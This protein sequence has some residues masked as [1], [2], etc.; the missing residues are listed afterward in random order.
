M[1]HSLP[2]IFNLPPFL[3]RGVDVAKFNSFQKILF[4]LKGKFLG[5]FITRLNGK[6]FCS[7][8]NFFFNNEEKI[9][10]E[11][12]FYK[13]TLKTGDIY[14]PNKRILRMVNEPDIQLKKLLES[15]CIADVSLSEGDV[16]IDCGA[17][18]GELNV[19][20]QNNDIKINYIAFEPDPETFECLKLN[21]P[22][23]SNNLYNKALSNTNSKENFY[24][25]NLGGN[26]SLINF[27]NNDSIIVST[28]TLDSFEISGKIKLIKIEAEGFEPEVLYGAKETIKNT[29]YISVD[30]G[31]ERGPEQESTIVEVN[32]LLYHENF[33]LVQFSEYRLIGL[34]ENK[35]I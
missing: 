23:S 27:G 12:N 8:I 22:E 19:A 4:I 28:A 3:F 25:D 13:K 21:N 34:Y 17:N 9:Y 26:S 32:K 11:N 15:Y 14:Y 35:K 10:Y 1:K 2:Y 16:I 24:I 18:V 5:F 6:L 31:F 33:E 7:L 20:I 29:E 30:Y